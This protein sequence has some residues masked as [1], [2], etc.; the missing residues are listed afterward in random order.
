MRPYMDLSPTG[1]A[2][3]MVAQEVPAPSASRMLS[4]KGAI[5]TS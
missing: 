4:E 1:S 5:R 3:I 2:A